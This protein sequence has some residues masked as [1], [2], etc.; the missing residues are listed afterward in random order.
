MINL[1]TLGEIRRL[2]ERVNNLKL[3]QSK[4]N[5]ILRELV[6]QNETL[7]R[8]LAQEREK[9]ANELELTSCVCDC[10]CPKNCVVCRPRDNHGAD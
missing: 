5:E 4:S 7:R 6:A 10:K 2:R 3:A 1:K 8:D 9:R